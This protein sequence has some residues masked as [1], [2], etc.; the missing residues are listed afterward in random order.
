MINVKLS[1]ETV[2][3]IVLEGLRDTIETLEDS[4]RQLDELEREKGVLETYQ[5]LDYIDTRKY[6]RAARVMVEY[7]GGNL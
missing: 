2:D 5:V 7:F 1:Y 6:L 4:L 3:A